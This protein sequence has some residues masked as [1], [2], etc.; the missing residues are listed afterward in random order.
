M[1]RLIGLAVSTLDNSIK[2]AVGRRMHTFEERF[3]LTPTQNWVLDHI[4]TCNAEEKDVFQRD[5]E[6]HFNIQRS[7]ATGILQ[8]M[9][10]NGLLLREASDA[11]ARMK[12]IVLTERGRDVCEMSRS[13]K[14]TMEKELLTGISAEDLRIFLNVSERIG[15]NAQKI[16]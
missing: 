4:Y 1:R 8:L 6:A 9:E 10:K 7:T 11:D 16:S 12:R 5:I 14:D 3:G 13:A 2:R 15:E